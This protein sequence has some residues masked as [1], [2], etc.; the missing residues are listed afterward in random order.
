MRF[1]RTVLQY[2]IKNSVDEPNSFI[3]I[4]FIKESDIIKDIRTTSISSSSF[5]TG[6][7]QLIAILSN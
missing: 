3:K 1:K 7:W 4:N 5:I 2:A 6:S